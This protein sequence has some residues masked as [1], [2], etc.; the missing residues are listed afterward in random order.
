M[1]RRILVTICAESRELD[2]E[3]DVGIAGYAGTGNEILDRDSF[4]KDPYTSG[5]F[6]FLFLAN[7]IYQSIL[8]S[9]L[10][11]S[12]DTPIVSD[13]ETTILVKTE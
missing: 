5:S 7:L 3:E 6:A 9:D 11:L 1:A 13:K 10:Y 12:G 8:Q 2:P 4:I